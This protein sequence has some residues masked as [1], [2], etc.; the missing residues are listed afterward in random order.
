[1]FDGLELDVILY[2]EYVDA[3]MGDEDEDEDDGDLSVILR[4]ED[5][6]PDITDILAMVVV[7]RVTLYSVTFVAE[8]P[9]YDR[10]CLVNSGSM[11][12][13]C[14]MPYAELRYAVMAYKKAG[15]N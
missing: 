3:L 7:R 8:F 2:D 14:T 9:E 11:T 13:I 12:F 10:Y 4:Q 1:M 5:S 6:D 15:L